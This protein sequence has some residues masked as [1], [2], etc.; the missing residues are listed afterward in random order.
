M[1]SSNQ[2]TDKYNFLSLRSLLYESRVSDRQSGAHSVLRGPEGELSR[3]G[4]L[5][6]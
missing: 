4:W 6:R 1:G 3:P 2:L 5:E